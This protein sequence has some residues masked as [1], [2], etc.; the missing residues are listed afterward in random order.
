VNPDHLF[1]GTQA[2]NVA[3]MIAKGRMRMG[4]QRPK[5]KVNEE[6]VLQI[7]DYANYLSKTTLELSTM[8][9]ITPYSIRSI[10]TKKT[11]KHI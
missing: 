8:Y 5:A 9:N 3:D 7:R 10:V 6:Q 11:W 2:D 1:V 4:S